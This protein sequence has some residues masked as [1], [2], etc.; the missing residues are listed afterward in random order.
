MKLFKFS[1]KNSWEKL[2]TKYQEFLQKIQLFS[3]N[4]NLSL[5]KKLNLDNFRTKLARVDAHP[6]LA[7]LGIIAGLL[8]VFVM[9][10]F[11]KSIELLGFLFMPDGNY[12]NFEA[13]SWNWRLALPIA[14]GLI[15]GLV[16]SFQKKEDF[17]AGIGFVIERLSLHQGYFPI[18]NSIN[19]F[20]V[21]TVSIFFGFVA[22]REGPAVHLGAATSSFFGKRLSLPN[23]SIRLLVASGVA[24]AIAASFNTPLAGVAFAMEVVLLEYSIASLTPIILASFV[25]TV[26]LKIFYGDSIAFSPPPL[27]LVSLGEIP[28]ILVLGL[29]V[30]F[31]VYLFSRLTKWFDWLKKLSILLRFI[32]VGIGTGALA[33]FLPEIMGISYDSIN[34]ALA[35]GTGIWV[36]LAL[37]VGKL[38]LTAA[39]TTLGAGIG[40]IAPILVVGAGIGGIFGLLVQYL[41]PLMFTSAPGLYVMLGMAAAMGALLEAPLAALLALLEMTHNPNIILPGMLV[42]I[43]ANLL[44]T[45]FFKQK[46][47]FLSSLNDAGIFLKQAPLSLALSRVAVAYVMERNFIRSMREINL[48]KAH[49]IL[50]KKPLWILLDLDKSALEEKNLL[51]AADLAR[52]LEQEEIQAKLAEEDFRIDLLNIP[53]QRFTAAPIDLSA[54]LEEATNK[55][56]TLHIETL[57]VRQMNAP[58]IYKIA[59]IVTR[60]HIK[61]YYS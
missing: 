1:I 22:G 45:G 28:I 27:T 41:N 7:I 40:V 8:T 53:A 61:N 50:A 49:E 54:T 52:Y 5:E 6:Q 51:P 16:L 14:G 12:E 59:G 11:R 18:R 24:A 9:I 47:Y 44:L 15:L 21:G 20:F 10:V 42:V 35:G 25:A 56:N 29:V 4:I 46:N 37:V 60:E 32:L 30:G 43:S 19:Q 33:I 57:F 39:T 17:R 55:M 48:E 2:K 26:V 13:L 36:L 34:Q 23:N 31:S 58:N 38:F 3:I